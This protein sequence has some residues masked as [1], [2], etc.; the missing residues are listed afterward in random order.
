[1][2]NTPWPA[3]VLILAGCTGSNYGYSGYNTYDYFAVDGKRDWK[4]VMEDG[5]VEWRMAVDK[6]GPVTV[7]GT[8]VYTFEYGSFDPVELF[9][10]I[11]WSSDGSSGIQIHS[12][13]IEG[14]ESVTFSTPIQ[15]A[16]PQM[17]PGD[18]IETSTDGYTIT[19]TFTA[20]GTCPNEWVTD[21]WNC[22]VFTIT[23]G[24]DDTSSPPFVGTWEFAADWGASRFQLPGYSS[25]W[26]LSEASWAA[27]SDE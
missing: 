16:D 17:A 22:L 23:D 1:M 5:S 3:I 11:E 12:F 10:S 9:H 8:D 27:E 13:S 25:E 6:S 26:V 14:G 18:F 20:T 15:V 7:N 4:Y 2:R 21:D 19:S 24:V